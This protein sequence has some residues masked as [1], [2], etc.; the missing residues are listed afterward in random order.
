MSNDKKW[1]LKKSLKSLAYKT[2]SYTSQVGWILKT[3]T[4]RHLRSVSYSPMGS[5]DQ[6]IQLRFVSLTR[7][8]D[9]QTKR[10]NWGLYHLLA[11]G[12]IRPRDSIEVCITYSPMGSS[13]QEIQLRFV[14]LTRQ[15]DHQT[16]R[17]KLRF[18]S[19][20]RQWDHQTK[21]FKLRFVSLTRQWDHQTKRFNWGLYHL[22]ANGI[23]RPRDSIEVCITY[24][25]IGSSDQEIQ[26]RFVSLTR[27]WDH[28]TKRFN[29]GLYHLLAN[30]I[31]R[32]RNSIEVCITYSPMGSSDQEIQLRFVSLTR[33]WDHQTKKFNWGLYH[34]LANGIIRPRDSNWGLYH[35][36][37]NGI[38]RPRDS[39]WGLYHLLA[40]G[41][42]RPRDSIE[43][44]ITYS[45]MGSSDQEI[46]L[47]FV[48]LTRQWDHQTKKFNWGLYHLLAN[49]I[50]RPRNSIEVCITYSPMG[51]SDQEIQLRFVSLTRQWDHQTK[52][53]KL[54]FVS[55]TRQWDHQTKRFKL[56]FVSLTR[57]WDHQTKRFNWGLYHLLVNGII[58]PR[59]S[60][61]V[62][63]TY[64]P[65]GSSDQEIQLRFVSLTRQ[66]DHQTKKFNWGLYH[67]LANGIIRPRNSIE[68]CITYSPM[69][70]SD[71]EIQIEVC[72]TYSPMGSSDQEIQIEVCITYSPMGSSDQ[73]IQLR[74]VSL[75]RQ[76]DHQTKR[77]N[78][79]LYHLL[80]NGIIRPRN[81]IEVCI[82]YS[83]M[84]SSDQEIQLRFVSLTRQWDHQTKKFNW[85]L[86]HL[87]ANGIIRPRNSIEVCI[88]YSP[89]GSSDQEIQLRFVSLTRQWDHQ[90][91]RFKLRFVS[92]TRQWDHQTKRFKLRF[93]SLTRQ[94]D[95]Q[96]KRFNWGLYHLLANGIIRPRDSIEVCIT[97]SPMGSSDQEI[98][99]RF[100]S[101]T[102]QWDHQTKKFNWGLYHLL[103]NGIIRPRNSIEVCITYSPMGSSDQE[104]QLRFVS[105]TRQWDHQTK[106]FNWGLYH[107][108][109]NGIIRPRDS[110]EV[111]ITYSP[112]G[113]SDH[114]IQLRFVSLTRQWD[115]QTKK[116]NWGLYHLLANGIIRPWDSIEVCI[117]YSSMGSSDQEIQLRFVSLTRQWDHQTKKFNWGLY[118]L[119][120]NGIIRPRNS[121]EVCITYS[122]M[123]SSD[124]EIQLRFVSL[125]RQWDHQTKKFNWGLYHLL[126]NGI[127]RPRNSIEVCI[128]YSPMG[129]SDQE[130]QLRFVSLT[131]QWDHQTKRFNWGLYHL[132]ANGIIRPR[133][134]NWGLYHLLANGIIRPRDSNWGLYHL[135]ANG[136][137]RPRDSIEVCITY[138]SMGSS[139]QEI[140]LRFVSLTR[141]WDHQ[142][143]KFNWGLYHLLANGIIR[144]RNSIEVCITYSP[145]G[146]SDQEIQL[147]FVSLT[148]QW[149]HQTK[150]FNWG[151][152]HLLANGIIRPRDSI[153]VCITYSPMGSSDQEIQIEVCITY[154]PMGSSDQEIQI[155]VCIT[156]YKRSMGD[157]EKGYLVCEAFLKVSLVYTT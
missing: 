117:T 151:L 38:I 35:L 100:V 79:G 97:Y 137:I 156:L 60:I 138:S 54:R 99:L 17:F 116:F 45:S 91:K 74:F 131:R 82:T 145:M 49:G 121:I 64:S 155:E 26:L 63:I 1:L 107:L 96:T 6:E 148:R 133:D 24:S 89:M 70:S 76:W 152:Y 36:L 81:S 154:S 34:L 51:S 3:Q 41:I 33:Q 16:K 39:N 9:H 20:T 19:L 132:L 73:E 129:S 10:F 146:S 149:D 52:R 93:V 11:N 142:T 4:K 55:L 29:W 48:S 114:E 101:L 118:H 22:L 104:I 124:Q 32:P 42:I 95:H 85:G 112:M 57:Q 90:T 135:L 98:Q 157:Y 128:T 46:Q 88:T 61:E 68:V 103:A 83:P 120:V 140:Q 28:Q 105:L 80:A 119:L 147:R 31:I 7:Q 144:P 69:G 25:S 92:L 110:I 30:G 13:D 66:W 27:Q 109:A 77:F 115:H 53:F 44:C 94:W 12:I 122:S 37:A 102:R 143:K 86:Y 125:T 71:Q 75:T 106:K 150:K 136:I 23:I 84:G 72:I 67:L 134:S 15:W 123:G 139:D 127:I 40:N 58:R 5:S 14:S 59:D 8:W 21:R 78:W 113:S 62:C 111:C 130:I 126:A 108:L 43:V 153:E 65:M 87:L 2:A 50:I 141:Q 18:V 56:R 47:R